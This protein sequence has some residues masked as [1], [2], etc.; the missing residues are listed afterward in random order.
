[1]S[2]RRAWSARCVEELR[3]AVDV[4]RDEEL[5]EWF[6]QIV[7]D[8]ETERPV[9]NLDEVLMAATRAV[10]FELSE[11]RVFKEYGRSTSARW[12]VLSDGRTYHSRDRGHLERSRHSL[13]RL[14]TAMKLEEVSTR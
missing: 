12:Y 8:L 9:R 7:A 5:R 11:A 6:L 14:E 13:H 3:V 1:M 2:D 10:E 4:T